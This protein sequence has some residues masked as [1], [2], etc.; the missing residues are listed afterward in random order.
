MVQ[1]SIAQLQALQTIRRWR[2]AGGTYMPFA[3]QQ[4][5]FSACERKGLIIYRKVGEPGITYNG[6]QLTELGNKY[7][8]PS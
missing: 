6:Y 4:R 8:G 5:T 2:V 7:A 1:I 3:S